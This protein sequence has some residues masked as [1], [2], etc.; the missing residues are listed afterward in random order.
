MKF[1]PTDGSSPI[2][3]GITAKI[4]ILIKAQGCWVPW[5]ALDL[6]DEPM[7]RRAPKM[8]L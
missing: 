7:V 6:T 1:Q 3:N 4:F 5:D 2:A 8:S